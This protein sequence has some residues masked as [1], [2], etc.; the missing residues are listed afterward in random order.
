MAGIQKADAAFGGGGAE[1]IS[2]IRNKTKAP[3]HDF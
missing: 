1:A 3:S 2:Y